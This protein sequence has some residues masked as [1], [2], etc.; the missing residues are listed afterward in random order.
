MRESIKP[1]SEN[2]KVET[3]E[4]VKSSALRYRDRVFTGATHL[5]ASIEIKKAFEGE[6]MNWD[7]VEEGFVTSTGRFI[8][9]Q[10]GDNMMDKYYEEKINLP[11]DD[12]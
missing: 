10:E 3:E 11:K 8:N 12:K 4:Y 2:K 5:D 1:E 7:T 6:A 9:R